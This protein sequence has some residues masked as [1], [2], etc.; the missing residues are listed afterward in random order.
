VVNFGSGFAEFDV[1]FAQGLRVDDGDFGSER[2]GTDPSAF[3]QFE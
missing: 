3:F 1:E 2:T